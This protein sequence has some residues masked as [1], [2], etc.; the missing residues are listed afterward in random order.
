MYVRNKNMASAA[1]QTET[2]WRHTHYS[3]VLLLLHY[4]YY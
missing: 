4:Y 1:D 3:A 2:G